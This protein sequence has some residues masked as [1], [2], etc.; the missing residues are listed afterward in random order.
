MKRHLHVQLAAGVIGA[1]LVASGSEVAIAAMPNASGRSGASTPVARSSAQPA[2]APG[3]VVVKFAKDVAAAERAHLERANH[4]AVTRTINDVGATVLKVP[5]GDEVRV[6]S[7]LERS[8]KV[9]Y[10]ERDGVV[11][12]TDTNPN[13]P[14]Y[15]YGG[16]T[17]YGGQWGDLYTQAPKTWDLTTGS[18]QV[19]VAVIDSGVDQSHPDLTA[20][21]LPGFNVL[22]GSSNTNDSYG[23]GTEV[24]G[25]IAAVTNNA[26]GVA[27]YC[28]QCRILPV[29]VY[30]SSNGA[31][32]SDIATGITWAA[33]HGAR[34]VNISMAG[35]AASSAMASAISYAQSR[36]VLVVGAAGNSG[37]DCPTYPASYPD[38]LAVAASDQYD[39]LYSYSNFG[40]WVDVAAP[41]QNTTTV[42]TDPSTGAPHGYNAFGGTSSAA[43][44]VAGIAG[45]LLSVSPTSTP[46]ALMAAI[47]A[48]VDPTTGTKSTAS[49]RVNAYK[50][51]TALAGGGAS[52]I[53]S[54]SNSTLPTITGTAQE[55]Q[56]LTATAGTWSG[57]P[58]SYAYQWQRCDTAGTTCAAVPGANSTTYVVTSADNSS[59]LRVLV[60]A[61]NSGGSSSAPSAATAVVQA[62]ATASPSPSPSPT[63]TSQVMTF[64]GSLSQKTTSRTFG[65]STGA[66]LANA[67][68]SFSKCSSLSLTLR[69]AS[70]AVL[71]QNAGPSIVS[72]DVTVPAGSYTYTVS[73]TCRTSFT[74]TVT[75]A[76]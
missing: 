64:G 56:T 12:P 22:D 62:A 7:A 70:G 8:G 1:A 71:G 41:G 27:G 10:A 36:G 61:T 33:D 65:L 11:L 51:V 46:A 30:N 23:H 19:A 63:S 29:K 26:A 6:V 49:G 52:T 24:A 5:A 39:G 4:A 40:S 55:G 54:P 50:A 16:S 74:L 18:T 32:A 48:N 72:V 57:S 47:T 60:T 44:V 59:T 25:V 75:A 2:Y 76:A 28:W 45:L 14:Y 58:T 13:D 3:R 69:T 35:S 20:N 43:P 67:K 15:P 17:P 53:T 73:G 34:V 42:L 66:G 21:L 38:V 31:Y 68:L 37:C 9:V